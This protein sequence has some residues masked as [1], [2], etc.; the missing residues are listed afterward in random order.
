MFK[1]DYEKYLYLL[2]LIKFEK[3]TDLLINKRKR[4]ICVDASR[5]LKV[6]IPVLIFE[7]YATG[8]MK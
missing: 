2:R 6:Q 5:Y 3:L 7:L 4:N 8:S 1:D